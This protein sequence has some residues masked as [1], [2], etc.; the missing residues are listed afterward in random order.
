LSG[1]RYLACGETVEVLPQLHLSFVSAGH[2]PGAAVTVLRYASDTTN[3]TCM[4]T[5]DCALA[6]GRFQPGLA[7]N[8]LRQWQP[9]VLLM[10]GCLGAQFYPQRRHLEASLLE[11]LATA[12]QDGLTVLVP[13]PPVGLGQELLFGLKTNAQLTGSE[14]PRE[15]WVDAAVTA[16]CDRYEALLPHLPQ[17]IQNFARTQS[18]FWQERSQPTIRRLPT[19]ST[20]RI[21]ALRS[22]G[23]VLCNAEAP[24][25]DW[26]ALWQTLRPETTAIACLQEVE[27]TVPLQQ[28]PADVAV[29]LQRIENDWHSHCDR[30]SL[31]QIV[32]TLRPHHLVLCNGPQDRLH[33]LAELADLRDRYIVHVPQ[34]GQT[35]KLSQGDMEHLAKPSP[36]QP[37]AIYEGEIEEVVSPRTGEVDAIEILLPAEIAD[38]AQWQALAETGLVEAK[39]EGEALVL[40]G[41][42]SRALQRE[43][44][45][46]WGSNAANGTNIC[47]NCVF[48]R[49]STSNRAKSRCDQPRSPMYRFAISPNGSCPEYADSE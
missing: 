48:F 15:I 9:D 47:A 43:A 46:N 41:M 1:W 26:N 5:G 42:S 7:L 13:V 16:G 28:W 29:K 2:L 20:E 34:I 27:L 19:T 3:F 11:C 21:A 36:E 30:Q 24:A 33:A 40:R 35:L 14:Y 10:D 38:R 23:I 39:W 18:L 12:L 8:Q 37:D 17:P 4:Y 44:N 25:E 32:H 49:P 6:S 31:L 45:A 22:P